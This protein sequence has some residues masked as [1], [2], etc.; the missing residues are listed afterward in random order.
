M[1]VPQGYPI[2]PSGLEPPTGLEIGEKLLRLFEE[3]HDVTKPTRSEI[4]S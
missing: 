1:I 2:G 4:A 3:P